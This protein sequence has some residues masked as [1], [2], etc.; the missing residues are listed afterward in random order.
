MFMKKSFLIL[1]LINTFLNCQEFK[2]FSDITVFQCPN[3]ATNKDLYYGNSTLPSSVKTPSKLM[4]CKKPGCNS[5]ERG[6][7]IIQTPYIQSLSG[8][9]SQII[10]DHKKVQYS[11]ESRLREWSL[12]YNH[13]DCYD[14]GIEFGVLYWYGL[15]TFQFYCS[16]ESNRPT[17]RWVNKEIAFLPAEGLNYLNLTLRAVD[18]SFKLTLASSNDNFITY[19]KTVNYTF[20]F[21]KWILEF[22][23]LSGRI[24]GKINKHADDDG[25]DNLTFKNIDYVV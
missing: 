6:G 1:V 22:R 24:T 7:E 16:I 23:N 11:N 20:K 12:F 8:F 2:S 15:K 13:N 17:Q 19:Y 4:W 21:E 3:R 9:S 14:G 25:M 10:W 18:Q 5:Y